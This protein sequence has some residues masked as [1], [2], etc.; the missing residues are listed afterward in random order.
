MDITVLFKLRY[1]FVIYILTLTTGCTNLFFQ[2]SRYHAVTPD[3]FDINYEDVYFNSIDNLKLHGW[4]FPARDESKALLLFLH[5]NGENISTHSAAVYWLT[6][7]QYDVFVFDYRGYGL[8]Q[9]IPDI[10]MVMTDIHQAYAYANKRKAAGKKLFV[11]GQSLGSSMGIY[12][13]AQKPTGI[14][15]A[16]F[17]SPFSDYRDITRN[18]LSKSWLTWAF[19]WP[20][21]LTISNDYRPLDYV[22]KLPAVPTLYLY[23]EEDRVIPPEQVKTL[24]ESANEPKYIERLQGPHS[25]IFSIKSNRNIVLKYLNEWAEQK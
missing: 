23:S 6:Q 21:S 3:Q 14:D 18:M 2:P 20:L 24:F 7:H 22:K 8:S 13:I 1:I 12:S 25:G 9:G 19:Q 4:W 11:M 10:D 5:G 16:I 15:G 17:V